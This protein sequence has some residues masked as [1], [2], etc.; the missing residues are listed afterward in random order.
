MGR[1]GASIGCVTYYGILATEHQT[2]CH[3]LPTGQDITQRIADRG[4]K[5]TFIHQWCSATHHRH[6]HAT[7]E[8]SM[9]HLQEN[10]VTKPSSASLQETVN[11]MEM[12]EG[13]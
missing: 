12:A 3:G 10:S 8:V 9:I 2:P 1:S 7:G 13:L 11:G 4:Q 5:T 6:W